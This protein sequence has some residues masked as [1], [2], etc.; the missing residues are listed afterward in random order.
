MI[1]SMRSMSTVGSCCR[2]SRTRRHS[3]STQSPFRIL[4]TQ[5]ALGELQVAILD[6]ARRRVAT[7]FEL[8][9]P[10]VGEISRDV[11]DRLDGIEKFDIGH[12]ALLEQFQH[13][14][15]R[16]HLEGGRVF[17]HVRV[18]DEQMQPPIETPVGQG[19]VAGVDDRPTELDP[20]VDFGDDVISP[21]RDLVGN[22]IAILAA[23]LEN[24]GVTADAARAGKDLSS[25]EKRQNGRQ[26]NLGERHVPAHEVIF[27][28]TEGGAGIVIDVVLEEG[29]IF[30]ETELLERPLHD[31]L[32][33]ALR[34]D[35]VEQA[36]AFRCGVLDV[37]HVDVD[38]AAV[39]QEA[40]VAGRFVASSIVDV[41][42][43]Q[44]FPVENTVLRLH[45][46]EIGT[47]ERIGVWRH[48]A[49]LDLDAVN[50]IAHDT[51]RDS[52]LQPTPARLARPA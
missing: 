18:A 45:R 32:A 44:T 20:L 9:V 41:D 34:G 42:D 11:P 50:T 3:S 2:A 13:E 38:T 52:D 6:L 16:P 12:D 33:S 24:I 7:V 43:P 8:H 4:A 27:V 51:T 49:I 29:G 25:D 17:G 40:A 30:G 31:H 23:V 37:T 1:Q 46:D 48:A 19:L 5:I 22:L 47:E 35:K 28:T 39:E 26:Q 14:G 15:R 36:A 10:S 21:L